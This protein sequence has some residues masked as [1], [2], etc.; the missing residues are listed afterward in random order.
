MFINIHTKETITRSVYI[1]LTSEQRKDYIPLDDYPAH[2]LKN[3]IK[4]TSI[5][6]G[7]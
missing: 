4:L 3:Q 6:Y 7:K 1:S 2:K 5:L